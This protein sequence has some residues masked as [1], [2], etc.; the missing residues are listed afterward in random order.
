MRHQFGKIKKLWS[1]LAISVLLLVAVLQLA[2]CGNPPLSTPTG[3]NIDPLTLELGWNK[4]RNAAY[5]TVRIEGDAN[6]EADTSVNTFSLEILDAGN[7]K[8]SVKAVVG[9]NGDMYSDSGWSQSLSFTR[10]SETGLV[11][12]LT[13]GNTA[14]EVAGVGIA[15]GDIT[16]PDTYRGLP[17][18]S[19]GEQAFYNKSNVTSVTLGKNIR[20]IKQQAFANCSFLADIVWSQE[21]TEIAERAFQN[22]R[23]LSIDLV[24]PDSLK[25]LGK[26]AFQYC[27]TLK[28]VTIGNTLTGIGEQ[29][30]YG[31]SEL[32]E[33]SLPDNV[34]SLGNGAFAACSELQTATMGKGVT[35][36]GAEAFRNCEKLTS[37][38]FGG[39]ETAIGDNAF[40]D[41]KLLATVAIPD[42]V[43]SVGAEAFKGCQSLFK[44]S[45]GEKIEHIGSQAFVNTGI[46]TEQGAVYVGNWFVGTNDRFAPDIKDGTVGIADYAFTSCDSFSDT[47]ILPD[48]VKFV[49]EGA[50]SGRTAMINFVLGKGVEQIGDYAFDGCT[51]LSVVI[52]GEWDQDAGVAVLG[53]S[54]LKIIGNYAF[55]DCSSLSSLTMP[56][57]VTQ[58]GMDCFNDSGLWNSAESV[59]YAGNWAVGYKGTELAN[60]YIDDGTAGI[61][62]YAFYNKI[63]LMGISIAD[64]VKY[65]GRSAFYKCSNLTTV[66]L[67]ETLQR[68]EDYTFYRCEKLYLPE[69]PETLQYIGRSAFYKCAL[70]NYDGD[71]DNDEL[72]I[73][74]SVT[75]IGDY[76]FYGCSY[77]YEDPAN[78]GVMIYGG[79]DSVL[80]GEGAVGIGNY[81]FAN[82]LSLKS[83]IIGNGVTDIG[84]RA[85]YKC[86]SLADV[87]FGNKV[88]S[89]GERAFYGC[90]SLTKV[91]LPV[92][93][94]TIENYA[95]YKCLSLAE[96]NLGNV[97]H[98][99]D[100]AFFGCTALTKV[101]IPATVNYIGA[102]AFRKCGL[103]SVVL[104]SSV[105]TLGEHLF[106]GCDSLTV[107]TDAVQSQSGWN[108]RWNSSYRPVVWGCTVDDEGYVVSF[109]YDKDTVTNLNESNKLSDPLRDG[110]GFAGW[111]LTADGDD[112]IS[113]E[114]LTSVEYG[115]TMYAVWRLL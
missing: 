61:S 114:Q 94:E 37:F 20:V 5:Y 84:Q 93:I 64:S 106:Y 107:Y 27:R 50:F 65:I 43:T 29:A 74:D 2:A 4:V 101:N 113:S 25:V 13:D 77:T 39:K 49:G 103:S 56:E 46:W 18:T 32:T 71:T 51:G 19:I 86:E 34:V 67:P 66:Y 48:S 97:T 105:D 24:L 8:V 58:I 89:V 9:A 60:V 35:N 26:Q 7:Y 36:I 68:I 92:T 44:V 23:S 95:F 38:T 21:L 10:E 72:K 12:R 69:L 81:A 47:V 3:L 80:T 41:C 115:T 17:V 14:Y 90:N 109:V 70:G 79:V 82:M 59:V 104:S 33:I 45:V 75:Y 6:R 52:L 99:G 16:V 31:C 102:Q 96:V 22:C 53:A 83:V 78:A 91:Q 88:T 110:Y 15:Q 98:I 111:S 108:S 100:Y 40:T 28:S 63:T 87:Q 76:A 62:D 73:P 57:T 30:F 112:V 85:F 55:R 1:F 11:F 54:S 42:S